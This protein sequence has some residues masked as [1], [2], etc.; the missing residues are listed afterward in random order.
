MPT[1]LLIKTHWRTPSTDLAM[2][3]LQNTSVKMRGVCLLAFSCL[4]CASLA[5]C[6]DV[7]VITNSSTQ[8][9]EQ[10]AAEFYGLRTSRYEVRNRKDSAAAIKA[11]RQE[12]VLAVMISADA[13]ASIDPGRLLAAGQRT[14]SKQIPVLITQIAPNT[15]AHLLRK[16]SHGILGSCERPPASFAKAVYRFSSVKDL[17]RQLSNRELPMSA[18]PSCTLVANPAADRILSLS[19]TAGEWPVFARV[20]VGKMQIYYSS[21]VE[22]LPPSS[23]HDDEAQYEFSRLAPLLMFLRYAAGA[24][25][26]HSIGHYAN[27]TVDDAWLREPYGHL[28]YADLLREMQLHNF[29]TTVAFIPWNFDRSQPAV[30]SLLKQHGDQFSICI[31]GN[32]HD[33][34]EFA[35]LKERPFSIQ[36]ANLGQAVARMEKFRAL[37]RLPYDRVMVFPHSV[38]PTEVL[39]SLKAH[40]YLATINSRDIPLGATAPSDPTFPLRPV[41]LAFGNFPSLR[42]YSAELPIDKSELSVDAFLDNPILFYV[43]EAYFAQGIDRFDSVAD[44]INQL[45]PDTSWRS[46]GEIAEHLYLERSRADGNFD[47]KAFGSQLHVENIHEK[48]AVFSVEKEEDFQLP[49]DVMVD[50]QPHPFV[51]IENRIRIEVPIRA[52]ASREIAIEYRDG[53]DPHK[54]DVSRRSL[55]VSA[56]RY[57]SDFRDNFVSRSEV[58][59]TAIHAY[60]EEEGRWNKAILT[61]GSVLLLCPVILVWIRGIRSSKN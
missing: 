14:A 7:V 43:H 33:H 53:F 15:D 17:T 8:R 22:S 52:G 10:I 51:R 45:Q 18:V 21:K 30:V 59:R 39:A 23:D 36:A 29:H 56:L 35:S 31:H 49:F 47:I 5:W 38:A 44:T 12:D 42:R 9:D 46:L 57:L 26:W 11:V 50:G 61:L 37:T 27:L 19:S 54:V 2:S 58:G 3:S 20:R 32:N 40:N 25:A 16:W 48:D 28:Q 13:L 60:A 24:S 55:R 6:S 1:Q 34:Q 41:T 4:A